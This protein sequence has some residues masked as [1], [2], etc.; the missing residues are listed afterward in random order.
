MRLLIHKNYENL[1][2][3]T[4]DY[5]IKRINN[6]SP[7]PEKHFVLGL[8][9][10]STPIGVYRNLIAAF[11]EG[12]VSFSS[13]TSFNMDEYLGLSA[14]HP[15]SYRRYTNDNF[16]NSVDILPENTYIP[17]G[18]AADPEKECRAY[19]DAI[20]AAGG[21]ELLMGGIGVNGHVAFNEPGSS[22][23]SRTR[24]EILSQE[25]RV[26]NSRFF[27]GEINKV[28]DRAYTIGIST[29]ME[30]RE[31]LIIISGHNKARALQAVVEG[32]VSHWCPLSSLQMHPSAIIV[33]DED[34]AEELKYGTVLYFK[35]IERHEIENLN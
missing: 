19:E 11:K 24:V 14:D 33:C 4:A 32:G 12:K 28:P 23:I 17:D 26:V 20:K 10:G 9:S 2:R 5:I 30:A 31:V 22:L 3:W 8:P 35:N 13:V 18:M 21:I 16:F 7:S 27:N 34:A 29:I 15:Q 1:C 25:T 6:F